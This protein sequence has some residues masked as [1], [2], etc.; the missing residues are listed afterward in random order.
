MSAAPT[1]LTPGQLVD[2]APIGIGRLAPLATVFA[3]DGGPTLRVEVVVEVPR[4]WVRPADL[5]VDPPP[6]S[7]WTEAR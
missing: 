2:L 6:P 7:S 4:D 5:T 1:V 3:D